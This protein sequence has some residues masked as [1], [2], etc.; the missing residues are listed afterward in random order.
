[1]ITSSWSFD[2]IG[3]IGCYFIK[4]HLMGLNI[5]KY[6]VHGGKILYH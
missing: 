6:G 4:I 2:K 3:E 5:L 1:M